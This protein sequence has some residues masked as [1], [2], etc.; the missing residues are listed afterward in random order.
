MQ[1]ALPAF[2]VSCARSFK[3]FF[4]RPDGDSQAAIDSDFKKKIW[5]LQAQVPVEPPTGPKHRLLWP[6]L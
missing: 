1:E 4:Q 3:G 6:Y 5:I 2:Y